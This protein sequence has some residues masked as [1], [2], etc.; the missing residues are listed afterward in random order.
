MRSVLSAGRLC[1]VVTVGSKL[2]CG[3]RGQHPPHGLTWCQQAGWMSRR[4]HAPCPRGWAA[5]R[6]AESD[7][8]ASPTLPSRA[9]P[10][11]QRNG[12]TTPIP[13]TPSV[14]ISF[15]ASSPERQ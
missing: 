9:L 8:E 3:Q 14:D 13:S 6:K 1:G 12:T 10:G 7:H 11:Q 5:L 15:S 4:E 2:Q